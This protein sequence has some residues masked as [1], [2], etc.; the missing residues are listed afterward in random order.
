V[1]LT[2]AEITTLNEVLELAGTEA[3]VGVAELE[4]P[5]EVGSL[6]EVGA[7][8]DDL[9]DEILHADDAVLAEVLLDDGVVGES[10][11]LAVDLAISALVDELLDAL[12]VGVTIG[13]PRLDNLDHLGGG[14]GDTDEDT[15]V[16]L[17]ETEELEDLARLGGDLVDTIWMSATES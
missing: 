2:V 14:L 11:A 3:A 17:E 5:Q 10:D 7:N 13:D 9:V 12:E 1:L 8:I 4:G 6:L 15:V 16:D